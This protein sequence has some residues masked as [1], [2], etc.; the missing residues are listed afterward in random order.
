MSNIKLMSVMSNGTAEK[1]PLYVMRIDPQIATVMHKHDFL[2]LVI[3][4]SGSGVHKIAGTS[5]NIGEGDIF[6]IP[7][8]IYH[9]YQNCS[10]DLTLLNI[11]FV[12]E[13]IP[14]PLLDIS[15]LPGYEALYCGR[16][17]R[18]EPCVFFHVEDAEYEFIR[19]LA[20][21][22]DHENELRAPGYLF[23][24]LGL[25]IAIL[26]KL[27]R[28][29]SDAQVSTK[30]FN[31]NTDGVIAYL[32]RH[33]KE[34]INTTR[35]CSLAGRSKASLMRNFV[36]ETGISPLQYQMQL[37]IAEAATLLRT[38]EKNLAEIA[39]EV[40][41]TDSNYF[42]RQFKRIIGDSPG[43]FREANRD[44]ILAD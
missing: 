22:L 36:R 10:P 39:Y 44:S 19:R 40:G 5:R 12:P 34:K 37:R 8:D 35:L 2:E 24:M 42:G 28:I 29:Y 27:V 20:V 38:T 18:D 13:L 9:Q 17:G 6:M 43:K 11:L 25:F 3:I 7:R 15:R 26:G 4:F 16:V 32:N 33:F 23:N 41:F 14:L 31:M 21:E 30:K 1:F